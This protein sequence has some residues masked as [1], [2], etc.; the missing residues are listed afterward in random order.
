MVEKKPALELI[1]EGFHSGIFGIEKKDL[2]SS[3]NGLNMLKIDDNS[4][5]PA[6]N[7]G[8]VGEQRVKDAEVSRRQTSAVHDGV[9][10]SL[11]ELSL[12]GG[13]DGHPCPDSEA[14]LF[15]GGGGGDGADL[16]VGIV[17]GDPGERA[18]ESHGGKARGARWNA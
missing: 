18:R 17:V 11:E 4:M 9:F 13:V 3:D 5:V 14:S 16:V 10:S 6:E 1:N 2:I 12:A 15:T 8:G 7:G